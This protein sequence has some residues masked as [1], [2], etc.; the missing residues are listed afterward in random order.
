MTDCLPCRRA[1][2]AAAA[3]L[4]AA[5]LALT[6]PAQALAQAQT[7]APGRTAAAAVAPQ[8]QPAP[9]NGDYIVA[10][11]NQELVT[12]GE[13]ERRI[14]RA[15]Q[16]AAQ[17]TGV[18]LPPE[19][20][21]RQQA[22]DSLIDERVLVTYARDSG[23]RVE[24]PD[25]DRAVLSIAQQNQL[26][27]EQMRDRMRADGI[28]Y[29]RFRANLRDQM[30]VERV[31]ER[32]VYQRIRISDLEIDRLVDQQRAAAQADAELNIAQILVTVPENASAAEREA[33]KARAEA[34]LARVRAGED[35]AKVAAE[36]SEDGNRAKGGEIGLRPASRLPDLF[37]DAVRPLAPGEITPTLVTSGAGYHV[38][39]LLDRRDGGALRV[40][41]T[42]A[43][44]ILL[45][46]SQQ[47]TAEAASRR[48]DELRRQIESGARSFDEA[49]RQVS[50]DGSA[51][52]GGDLGWAGPGQFVPEFEDAMNKLP[53]GGISAPVVSR[54]GVH[55]IQ[56]LERR[57]VALETKQ[58]R[59]QARNLLREQ[60]FDEAYGEWA[61]ELRARAYV[62]MREPPL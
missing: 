58:L 23:A 9:L 43:R 7:A 31:R 62:E 60:K 55:L 53:L 33:R 49:A 20:E 19:S 11:V 2:A 36:L 6:A 54:F 34:A 42:H 16:E 57:E 40:A 12:A 26:T 24:E 59:E 22:M 61:R 15:Q 8:R 10:V 47:L 50:D 37:V 45:R 46:T 44:H 41:Q 39:K 27:L 56:V 52:N 5:L 3:P 21:L 18:R 51:A 14:E 48:L 25:L 29:A 30:L 35:F 13:V 1:A 4:L 32:E 28:D 38:L 17:R